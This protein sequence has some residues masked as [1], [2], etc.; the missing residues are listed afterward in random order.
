[1]RKLVNESLSAFLSLQKLAK[2]HQGSSGTP[3][4]SGQLA[5]ISRQYR[6][7]IR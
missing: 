6:S 2:D 7:I 1:M 3:L 4:T 5:N